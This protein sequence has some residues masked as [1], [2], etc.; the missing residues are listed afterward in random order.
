MYFYRLNNNNKM[1]YV[2]KNPNMLAIL[3]EKEHHLSLSY[4]DWFIF[5]YTR[6]S[7][8]FSWRYPLPYLCFVRCCTSR[9]VEE[10]FRLFSESEMINEAF[11]FALKQKTQQSGKLMKILL[12]PLSG[13]FNNATYV[14]TFFFYFQ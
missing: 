8:S 1:V 14:R 2:N 9:N 6:E 11:L 12:Y 3:G 7:A 4:T 13:N 5:V 10:S